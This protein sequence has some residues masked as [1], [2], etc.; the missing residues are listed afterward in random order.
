MTSARLDEVNAKGRTYRALPRL[1]IG[2]GKEPLR[3][4]RSKLPLHRGLC[5][6]GKLTARHKGIDFCSLWLCLHMPPKR[7]MQQ[8]LRTNSVS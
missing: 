5:Q 7:P 4:G 1:Y 2:Q 3:E 6:C 8:S